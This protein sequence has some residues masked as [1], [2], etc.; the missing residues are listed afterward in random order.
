MTTSFNLYHFSPT[1]K[2][3][4]LLIAA[5]CLA[6]LQAPLAD[7]AATVQLPTVEV[8]GV[9]P[10]H[11]VGLPKSQIPVNV[12]TATSSDLQRASNPD[13]TDYMNRSLGSVNINEAQSN[14]LQ[15]DVQYRGFTA[16][17]LLGVPQGL[18]VYVD[19]VRVNEP[20]GD[21]VNW[22]LIPDSMISSINLIGGANPLFGQ[23]TLGGAL[24]IQTK[25]G[26]TDTGTDIVTSGG[27][28]GRVTTSAES[29]GN[30]GT[31]G[32]YAN[33][34]YFDEDGWRDSSPSNALNFYG[35]VGWHTDKA[36]LDLHV[37]HGDTKLIG[38]GPIP[39]QLLVQDRN[40]FFTATDI[41]Q[42]NAQMVNLESTYWLTDLV[43]FSGN[44][45]YRTNDTSSFNSDTSP[46]SSN[47]AGF[48]VDE[49]GNPVVDQ[50]G[51]PAP[52]SFDAVNNSSDTQQQSYGGTAQTTLLHKLFGHENQ[53]IVGVS[54]NQGLVQFRSGT[55]LATLLPSRFTSGS[56]LFVPEGATGVDSTTRTA[57]AFFTDTFSLTN[58]LSLTAAGRYNDTR[59]DNTD[60]LGNNQ[61]LNGA[62][63]YRRFNPSIG[64][65]WQVLPA[66]NLYANYSESSRA[67]TTLEL[68]CADPTAPCTLP[69]TLLADPPLKEV[70]AHS[71]E[72]GARGR[73]NTAVGPVS[74][75]LGAF[76]TTNY[77]DIVFQT[78][79]GAVAT[80]G[81]FA[82]VGRTRRQGMELGL[83]G[84]YGPANWYL[85]YSFVHATFEDA[86]IS[87]SP[88]HPDAQNG[89]IPVKPGDRIPGIPEHTL[90]TGLDYALTPKL[91][92][93]GD[94]IY[95]SDQYL[96]GDEA[97]LLD[98]ISGYAIVNVHGR[99]TIN[100]HVQVFASV[101][102][103]FDTNYE[104]FGVLGDPTSVFPNFTDTRFLGPGAPIGGWVGLK[105]T[106]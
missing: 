101:E 25:N 9:T 26:F 44:I 38:L 46:Y 82:N 41:T 93:G 10:V 42:N 73:L 48:L 19:G 83:H 90:K 75:N 29:G 6:P 96:R 20:F 3:L 54:W 37:M 99:Y 95:N 28:F 13:L 86:F 32:Y 15:P 66:L 5:L 89:G 43:Q 100:K 104:T 58:K 68:S 21:V 105:L 18:A 64:L 63:D 39:K 7:D 92:V 53:F 1:D 97:N 84:V 61:G 79:G 106:F 87:S 23:N 49:D 98:P 59:I 2:R 40:T 11:G 35:T 56:G 50:A 16:S 69:N 4:W 33:V 52:D 60:A 91:I 24:S 31:L 47:G 45:Y 65:T 72:G 70:F 34:R 55:E 88:F 8:V 67:P 85:N 77:N 78:T 80:Q 57:S 74:W 27:S 94:L 36:T 103:L 71:Y 14:T 76:R 17:P 12:Q 102:N 22:D 30:N 51:N 62:H 81:F